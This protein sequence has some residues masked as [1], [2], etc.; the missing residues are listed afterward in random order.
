VEFRLP[1]L[2]DLKFPPDFARDLHH[3]GDLEL[4]ERDIEESRWKARQASPPA[5][6]THGTESSIPQAEIES[7]APYQ[8]FHT[9][10][11]V[12]LRVYT[13]EEDPLP[14]PSVSALLSPPGLA[15]QNKSKDTRPP[16]TPWIFGGLIK[17]KK[18]DVGPTH[19]PEDEFDLPIDHRALP[20]SAIERVMRVTDS[21]EEV[22]HIVITTRRRKGVSRTSP[23][24]IGDVD[25][26][27]FFED[28]CEVLDFASQRV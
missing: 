4:T 25:E 1:S 3:V 14:S 11:R 26:E 28:D 12:A 9:D 13:Y 15:V 18:L 5:P 2:P 19:N 10:Q 23:D 21:T 6:Q 8:P 24:G 27:G 22:E 16:T 17:S 20:S 7:N